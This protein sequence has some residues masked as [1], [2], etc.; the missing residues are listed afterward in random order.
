MSELSKLEYALL[1]AARAFAAC[2][3]DSV[4]KVEP[5]GAPQSKKAP[6]KENNGIPYCEIHGKYHV[7]SKINPGYY[8][9]QCYIDKKNAAN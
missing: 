5:Q 7:K 6:T 2:Y 8:C 4:Q 1:C 9:L 3:Q